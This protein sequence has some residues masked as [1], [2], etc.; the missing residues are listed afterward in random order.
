[1]KILHVSHTDVRI[2]HRI[3]RAVS[4]GKDLGFNVYGMG[5]AQGSTTDKVKSIHTKNIIALPRAR[6]GRRRLGFPVES[7]KQPPIQN[8]HRSGNFCSQAFFWL[9][10]TLNIASVVKSVRPDLI[11]VH[12]VI[13]LPGAV[14]GKWVWKSQ[15]V[16]DAHEL[17][18][19]K[20]GGS[21]FQSYLFFLVEKAVWPYLAGFVTVSGGIRDWYFEQ[22]GKPYGVVVHNSIDSR[23]SPLEA[24]IGSRDN[25]G[26]IFSQGSPI[27]P[28]FIYVGALEKGRGLET[29]LE[30]FSDPALQVT[31]ALLG[32]GTLESE[33]REKAKSHKNIYFLDPVPNSQIPSVIENFDYGWCVLE[34]VSL[35]DYLSLPNKLFEYL[36]SGLVPICSSFPEMSR[37]IAEVGTGVTVD[38]DDFQKLRGEILQLVSL[39]RPKKKTIEAVEIYSW[40]AQACKLRELYQE[41]LS[42]QS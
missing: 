14:I 35:S 32:S 23:D 15:L 36:T 13:A 26:A 16:Y 24:S 12:D 39:G 11:H 21:R 6:I 20:S 33:L 40:G 27:S 7:Q 42:N 25:L 3:L 2:D 37:V 8:A 4:V 31:F 19:D 10:L 22:L 5:V 9:S 38:S 28:R 41:T 34:N 29:A 18:A 17:H 30:L 1:M